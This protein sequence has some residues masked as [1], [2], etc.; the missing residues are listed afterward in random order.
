MVSKGV[1]AMGSAGSG[2]VTGVG[3]GVTDIH[4]DDSVL[5][6]GTGVWADEVVVKPE[7]VSIVANATA[8]E[9]ASLPAFVSA[10]TILTNYCSTPLQAGD[11]VVQTHANGAIG[12][13]ISAIGKAMG[14]DVFSITAAKLSDAK[15][16]DTL[17][18]KGAVKLAV[19][20]SAGDHV[21]NIVRSLASGGCAVAYSA[22]CQ[23][24][25]D[26]QPVSLPISGM[27]FSNTSVAGFDLT[28][29]ASANPSAYR[30]AVK[31][32]MTMAVDSKISL[33]PGKVFPQ[34][35]FA[36]ALTEVAKKGTAAILKF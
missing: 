9:I 36:T 18:K 22:E 3:S 27:I 5:V 10:Y 2:V 16:A 19:I 6:V 21:L 1:G 33:K 24:T 34:A 7:A 29:F 8:E 31:A 12:A 26:L 23:A 35:E 13:A 14:L 15:L 20:G 32:V 4:V 17:K 11:L 28:A 30:E 25:S